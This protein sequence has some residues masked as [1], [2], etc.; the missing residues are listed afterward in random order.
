MVYR[1]VSGLLFLLENNAYLCIVKLRWA[2]LYMFTL[3][4]QGD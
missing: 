3:A 1:I 2:F 4:L